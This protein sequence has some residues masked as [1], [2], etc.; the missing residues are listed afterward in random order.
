MPCGVLGASVAASPVVEASALSDGLLSRS[1]NLAEC[2]VALGV[3]TGVGQEFTGVTR[4]DG[5]EPPLPPAARNNCRGLGAR[6]QTV[7]RHTVVAQF[8]GVP[9]C[10]NIAVS[11]TAAGEMLPELNLLDEALWGEA[12]DA[13]SDPNNT[14]TTP[15]ALPA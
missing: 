5:V 1:N 11:C 10:C 9:D 2:A 13:T 3:H 14:L 4:P 7:F 12:S 8:C 6:G 15:A